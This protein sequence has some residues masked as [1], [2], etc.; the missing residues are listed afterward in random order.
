MIGTDPLGPSW[1]DVRHELFTNEE[2]AESN[3]RVALIG[4]IVNARKTRGISQKELADLAKMKVSTI[5]RIESGS[6]TPS[7]TTILK[8]L[9]PLGKTLEI[10]DVN[11]SDNQIFEK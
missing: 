1:K 8:I 11:S 2:I 3:F 4:E 5:A 6:I 7:I 10:I 9:T